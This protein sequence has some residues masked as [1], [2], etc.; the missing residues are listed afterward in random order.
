M[1]SNFRITSHKRN[2]SL[3]LKLSGDFDGTSAL[4]L[5]YAINEKIGVA[6]KIYI[7]TEDLKSLKPFGRMVFSNNFH[8]S[9]SA[10]KK[11]FFIGDYGRELYPH[12]AA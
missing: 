8:F 10:L 2:G 5:L 12:R 4:E 7:E 1:A 3:H 11:I 9:A 6:E